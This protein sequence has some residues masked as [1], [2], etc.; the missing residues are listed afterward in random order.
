MATVRKRTWNKGTPNEK[1]AWIADY[2]DQRGDRHIKTFDRQRK[3]KDW[4]ADTQREVEEGTHTPERQSITVAEA[5]E[6]W[7]R[8]AETDRLDRATRR[9]Y[10]Q[11]LD[12]HIKPFI[13]NTKLPQLTV[14][15]VK[16]FRNNLIASGRSRVMAKKVISSLGAVLGD[17]QAS[18][19]VAQNVVHAA[20]Q[21]NRAALRRQRMVE[22]REEQ[23]IREGVD[24]PSKAELSAML[25]APAHPRWHALLVTAVFSGLR[26]S[27]LRALAWDHVKFTPDGKTV[28][29][30]VRRRADRWNKIENVTKS[31]ASNRDVE[32]VIPYAVNT[33]KAWHRE[34]PKG[35]L[36]LVFPNTLGNV[37]TLPSIH[38]RGLAPLQKAAG[39]VSAKKGP[40]YGMHSLRHVAASLWIEA[41]YNPK[42]VQALMGHSTIAMTLDTY[43]H[44]WGEQTHD[45]RVIDRQ[46]RQL[47][48][49]V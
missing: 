15:T 42:H 21:Q 12:L 16:E 26:A 5:G 47:G 45:P 43:T 18:G 39:I 4:L 20:A 10:R 49:A 35:A 48:L 31:K 44:L 46:Q 7:L 30:S 33:L 27:E 34:C 19:R 37:E 28:A 11:H 23:P 17:A 38:N 6:H 2:F 14:A 22:S 1:T 13:G 25:A 24:F 3:A 32:I 36:D 41:G 8:Q 29:I 9:Q 40:K